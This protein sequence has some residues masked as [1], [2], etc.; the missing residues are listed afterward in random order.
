MNNTLHSQL[1][2]L[3]IISKLRNGQ[4]LDITKGLTIYGGGIVDWIWRKYNHDNKHKTIKMLQDLYTSIDQT[5]EQ[6]VASIK[7]AKDEKYDRRIN[8]MVNLAEKM[9]ESITGLENL[10]GTYRQFP[11]TVAMIEG[12]VQDYAIATYTQLLDNIPEDEK[13]KDLKESISF[14]GKIIY[15]GIDDQV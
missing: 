10:L 12:V 15:Q 11:E 5:A 9:K 3:R 6:L 4:K 2:A 14:G 7:S 13:T 1:N 8:I